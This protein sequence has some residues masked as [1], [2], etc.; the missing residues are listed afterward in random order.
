ME[1]LTRPENT[2]RLAMNKS[3]ISYCYSLALANSS[4]ELK[5]F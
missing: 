4:T 1:V 5:R 3:F 2:N